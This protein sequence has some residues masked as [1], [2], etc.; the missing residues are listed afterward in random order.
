MQ[1]PASLA[2]ISRSVVVVILLNAMAAKSASAVEITVRGWLQIRFPFPDGELIWCAA[3][4][5]TL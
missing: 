2:E 1:N 5:V 4:D 3:F